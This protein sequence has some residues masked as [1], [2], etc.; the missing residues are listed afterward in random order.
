[1]ANHLINMFMWPYQV[2]FGKQIQ[3]LIRRALKKLGATVE[4]EVLIVGARTPE[5][6]KYHAVCI[7]PEDDKWDV[8]IFD[9]LLG[10]IENIYKTHHMQSMFFSD[11]AS[12]RDKPE[13]MRRSSVTKAVSQ[14]IKLFDD[15][16]SV[17]SF[18]GMARRLGDYYVTPIIQ[19]PNSIFLQF[20]PLPTISEGKGY[21]SL[22]HAAINAVL[23]EAI[24]EL[25]T[26]EPGRFNKM[27]NEEELVQI[28]AKNFMHTAGASIVE[29]YYTTDLF[30]SINVVSSLMYEGTKGIGDLILVSPENDEVDFI[31]KFITPVG[32]WEPRWVRKIL[33]MASKGIG[34]IADSRQ[35]Y[36]LGRLKETHNPDSQDAFIVSCLEIATLDNYHNSRN[37][38][39]EHRFYVN[40]QQCSRI[41]EAIKRLDSLPKEVGLIYIIIQ[42]FEVN[43][44]MDISYLTD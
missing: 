10:S 42:K 8:I 32:F 12:M 28:A 41:N 14:F 33:Q 40:K 16:N 5:S 39:D 15:M 36:G 18:C 34:I 38:L 30:H 4:A 43:P 22:I 27:R 24:Q 19:I 6:E 17:T 11:S 9:G 13:W 23:D 21:R 29:Q 1:M 3:G 44:E 25:E 2:S 37:W 26:P 20:P 31:V 35:I 7:E